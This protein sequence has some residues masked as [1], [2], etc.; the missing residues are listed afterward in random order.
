MATTQLS[1]SAI[2]GKPHSFLPKFES[3]MHVGTFTRLSVTATPG[4]I[5][6]FIAKGVIII[7]PEPPK[8]SMR[9][10]VSAV[11]KLEERKDILRDDKDL[12]EFIGIILAS[13][14]LDT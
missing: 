2:P 1:I 7:P 5:H 6:S 10:G 13:G 8:P 9:L 12:M 14:I 3:G 4:R 11:G